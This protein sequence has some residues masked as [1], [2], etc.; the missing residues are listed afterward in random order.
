MLFD[1][2]S[3]EQIG[4]EFNL[5]SRYVS[6][7]RG[8][9]R[10]KEVWKLFTSTPPESSDEKQFKLSKEKRLL[11]LD[12]ISNKN[13]P[14]R[15]IALEYEIDPSILSKVSRRK[16]WIPLWNFYDAQRLSKAQLQ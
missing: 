5:H 13:R 4:S 14:L 9:K 12:E 7:I 3:N 1:G 8:K 10:W 15:Q 11:I 2:F 6:L 16:K